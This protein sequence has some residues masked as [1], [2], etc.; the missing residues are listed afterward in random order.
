M[1]ILGLIIY[2][3]AQVGKY[4]GNVLSAMTICGKQVF[5]IDAQKAWAVLFAQIRG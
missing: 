1:V 2:Q 4:G 5:I 3:Q